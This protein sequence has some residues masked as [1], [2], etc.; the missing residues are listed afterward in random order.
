M[1]KAK[2]G[3]IWR[4]LDPAVDE[5]ALDANKGDY[6][7]PD[8]HFEEGR[9]S[10]G[11]GKGREILDKVDASSLRSGTDLGAVELPLRVS[12][13]YL[14]APLPGLWAVGWLFPKVVGFVS[15]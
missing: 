1:D 7:A 10:G 6:V 15:Q 12:Q 4:P 2:N 5:A 11:E 3:H 9:G 13:P 14:E 8:P